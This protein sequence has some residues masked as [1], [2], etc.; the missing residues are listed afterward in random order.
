MSVVV[1][2]NKGDKKNDESSE[3]EDVPVIPFG[4]RSGAGGK[5]KL[6]AQGRATTDVRGNVE[7]GDAVKRRVI[8]KMPTSVGRSVV[9]DVEDLKD[10]KEFRYLK[11][12]KELTRGKSIVQ[13]IEVEESDS[14]EDDEDDEDDDEEEEEEEEEQ[15]V[16]E[17]EPDPPKA[18][19][20]GGKLALFFVGLCF[21]V[22]LAA[23]DQTIVAT[24][25]PTI[26]SKLNG[27]NQ[28]SWI[29]TAYLLTTTSF[30][31]LYGRFSDIFGRKQ[32]MMFAICVFELGSLLCGIS[33][34]MNMLIISRAVAGIGGAGLISLVMIVISDVVNARDRGKYQGVIGATFGL[35]SVIGPLLGGVFTDKVSWHWCFFINLPFGAITILCTMFFLK[36]PYEG[37]NFKA[38]IKR[39][40]IFGIIT[41]IPAIITS[42]LAINWGGNKKPWDSPIVIG[43]FII[44]GALIATFI[45]V[46]AKVSKEPIIP[47][48]L[49][50]VRNFRVVAII[51]FAIGFCMFAAF[52]YLPLYFQLA[53]GDSAT[54]SGLRMLPML[55]GLIIFS[56]FS[57]GFITRTGRYRGLPVLGTAI[58][59]M[60]MG[61]L[62]LL[63][64]NSS[65]GQMVGCL[66]PGGVGVGLVMQTMILATQASVEVRDIATATAAVNFF[67]SIGG[68]I[69]VAVSGAVI[70]NS[71]ISQF[72]DSSSYSDMAGQ[73]ANL[74]V[75]HID[76]ESSEG[77]K[78]FV[79]EAFVKSIDLVFQVCVPFAGVGWI[80]SLFLQQIALPTF[81]Q[82]RR[83]PA[84]AD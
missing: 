57:G 74:D 55:L 75:S 64:M 68:V 17:K 79:R 78:D 38:K 65:F 73:F 19:L 32:T 16:E 6:S 33:T 35:A 9:L 56:M 27:F 51:S 15:K 34:T 21:A 26:A 10:F 30:Q 42:L 62:S 5:A 22:F 53:K 39:I 82:G 20:T 71:M 23:L 28:Y 40:D 36:L 8:S 52:I 72:A 46:Q 69:G 50:R 67:R 7:G 63:D 12:M 54:T 31:P 58:L 76:S 61:I 80:A 83:G 43:L 41:L 70:T 77:L 66:I 2:F 18:L 1:D 3:E 81:L 45:F 84:I 49:F 14:S 29:S 59:T 24:S 4:N 25:A 47:M 44:A 11:N 48:R 13:V 60:G 37:G